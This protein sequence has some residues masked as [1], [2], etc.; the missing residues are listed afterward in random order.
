MADILCRR[1]GTAAGW[2]CHRSGVYPNVLAFLGFQNCGAPTSPSAPQLSTETCST[3][4][5]SK[6]RGI[7][8]RPAPSSGISASSG[9]CRRNGYLR[10]RYVGTKGT[11]LRETRDAIQ[12]RAQT[13]RSPSRIP[14]TTPT[15]SLPIHSPMRRLA[16]VPSIR[17]PETSSFRQRRLVAL[18]LAAIRLAPFPAL[19]S[20]SRRATRGRRLWTPRRP[21]TQP[22]TLRLTIRRTFATRTGRLI[23]IA[24]TASSSATT[25]ICRSAKGEGLREFCWAVGP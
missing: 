1:P 22:S 16:R 12:P 10:V 24:R 2:W 19:T 14:P 8:F 4:S 11:H 23:L 20:I 7:S 18:Q 17:L 15:P 21:A 6:Y 9:N 13:T 3:C 5:V 25:G